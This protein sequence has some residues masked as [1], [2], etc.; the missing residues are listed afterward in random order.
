MGRG[1]CAY[2]GVGNHHI[3]FRVLNDSDEVMWFGAGIQ[4]WAANGMKH[5]TFELMTDII[6]KCS[7]PLVMFSD[8]NEIVSEDEKE[9]GALRRERCMDMFRDTIDD[10]N[11]HDLRSRSPRFTWQRGRP[12]L[13]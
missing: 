1:E 8:F 3:L 11:L 2:N 7:G 13:L 4:G 5:H 6:Q 9:G 12:W 10:C